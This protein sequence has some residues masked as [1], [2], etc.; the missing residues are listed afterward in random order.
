MK[1]IIWLL[2]GLAGDLSCLLQK[3]ESSAP[4]PQLDEY[5]KKQEQV[6]VNMRRT[7]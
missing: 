4:W 2:H 3:R 5:V 7:M 1:C 6:E